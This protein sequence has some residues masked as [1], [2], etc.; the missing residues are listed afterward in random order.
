MQLIEPAI[1]KGT[2][3]FGPEEMSRR[4]FIIGSLRSI[5]QRFGYQP[6]ETPAIEYAQ[7]ILGKYGDEGNKLT[8]HFKDQGDR[9]IA[10]RYDQTVPTARFVAANWPSLT[11][12]FKRYQIGPVWRADK[13]QKGRYREFVQC[14]IDIIGTDSLL[15]DAEIAHVMYSVFSELEFEQFVIRVNSRELLDSLLELCK[16]KKSDRL[17]VIRHLDK[18]DKVS[19]AAVKADLLA[20]LDKKQAA[21]IEEH[22]MA[23][24]VRNDLASLPA[25][26]ASEKM[27]RLFEHFKMMGIDDRSIKL[28]LTLARGLDYYTGVIYEVIIPNSGLGSLCGGGR[29]DNLTGLFTDKKFPGTGVAFGLDRMMVWLTEHGKLADVKASSTV[30]VAHFGDRLEHNIKTLE[31]MHQAGVSAE[32][33]LE[34]AKLQKQFKYADRKHIPWMILQG[35]QEVKEGKVQLRNMT[36]GEQELLLI[37]DTFKKI[38]PA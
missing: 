18:L 12:P 1:L 30:L 29:Y 14:D 19:V 7:T 37:E 13:P 23:E 28:D 20:F 24:D 8:Y 35:D 3:D 33:F 16:I 31:A 6:L 25:N 11:F 5:F 2:R 22:I 38:R 15:A 32:L 34:P 27:S 21:L 9:H 36:S 26:S 10:L 17:A 4:L